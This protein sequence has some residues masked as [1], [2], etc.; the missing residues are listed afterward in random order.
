MVWER[1]RLLARARIEDVDEFLAM[2]GA[3]GWKRRSVSVAAD[4]LRAFFRYAETRGWCATGFAKG[5]Q[6]PKSTNTKV[7]RGPELERGTQ[8]PEIGKGFGPADLRARAVLSLLAIYGL[9]SSEVSRLML[10]DFDWREEVFEVNHSK[11]G[12]P[13]R[14][15]LRREVGD[16]ILQYLKR[17]ARDVPV[18]TCS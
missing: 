10:S 2:K 6:G 5:I 17:G 4:A 7:S 11:R 3:C 18:D 12:S 1:H 15:P 13:Q 16:A 9:R 14:Y 8:A